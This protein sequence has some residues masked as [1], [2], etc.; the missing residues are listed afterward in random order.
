MAAKTT[1]TCSDSTLRIAMIRTF[2]T[3]YF[4]RGFNAVARLSVAR[5][6]SLIRHWTIASMKPAASTQRLLQPRLR[7][8]AAAS[9]DGHD[10][11]P[12][13]VNLSSEEYQKEADR[14]LET[15][16]DDLETLSDD[17]P[18]RIPDIELTQGVMT[19]QVADV[20]TYVINKQ[21][22]NKQIWLSSPISG[23]NRFDL[24]KGEWI[25]L[26]DGSKLLETLSS[27][28]DQVIPEQ[29]INLD[30]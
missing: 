24:Y 4:S 13:I 16:L 17:L 29:E 12:E 25:S 11:P 27:E 10:I 26:R 9:T 8:Y 2:P 19:L 1:D 14:C 5:N 28:L 15:L 3:R 23:P 18:D 21:P 22:P 7:F 20:G 6:A 30:H